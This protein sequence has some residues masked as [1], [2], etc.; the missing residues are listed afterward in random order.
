MWYVHYRNVNIFLPLG[1]TDDK[2]APA[3]SGINNVLHVNE[4]IGGLE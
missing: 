3:Y 1:V 2:Y 4:K